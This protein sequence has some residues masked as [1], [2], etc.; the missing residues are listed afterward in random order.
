MRLY[1]FVMTTRTTVTV[2]TQEFRN[3]GFNTNH[4]VVLKIAKLLC[5][6]FQPSD[7]EVQFYAGTVGHS[8]PNRVNRRIRQRIDHIRSAHRRH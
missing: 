6:A 3:R 7:T 5:T 4:K 2:V 1:Q 8:S